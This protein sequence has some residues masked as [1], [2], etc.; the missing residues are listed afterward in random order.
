MLQ[1]RMF[2]GAAFEPVASGAGVQS[3]PLTL[4]FIYPTSIW[5]HFYEPGILPSSVVKSIVAFLILLIDSIKCIGSL[6]MRALSAIALV[7]DC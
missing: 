4:S 7:M 1:P 6:I 5:G 2:S 3:W